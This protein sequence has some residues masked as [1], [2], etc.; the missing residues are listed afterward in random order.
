MTIGNK[1]A[2]LRRENNMTQEQLAGVLGVSRQSVS[3]WESGLAYPETEKLIKLSGLFDCSVDYLLKDDVKDSHVTR[4][5]QIAR[6]SFCDLH[7]E[8]QNKVCLFGV[9]LVHINV[10]LGRTAKGLIA[11]GLTAVGGLSFGLLSIGI[12]SFGLLSLGL[13]ALGILAT[14]LVAAG[15]IALGVFAFGAVAVGVL[16]VGA[17]SVGDFAIGAL[18]LGRYFALGDTASAMV[19]IGAARAEGTLYEFCSGVPNVLTGYDAEAVSLALG[20]Y[21]PAVLQPLARI[22]LRMIGIM[23]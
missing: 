10:G 2:R 14:G 1:I 22:V 9:P 16:A 3:K 19:A 21:V 20:E 12:L 17:V 7:Y 6:H 18:A 4:E 23:T 15:S 11:V 13:F 5:S 8:W